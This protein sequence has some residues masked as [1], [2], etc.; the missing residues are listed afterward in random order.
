MPTSFKV[1]Q[2]TGQAVVLLDQRRLP[3]REEYLNCGDYESV[4]TAITEMVVRGAPAIGI[5]AAYG[6]VLGIRD[7]CTTTEKPTSEAVK[8]VSRPLSRHPANR[9]ESLLG[10]RPDEGGRGL[11]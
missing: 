6:V 5:T 4:A 11:C 8:Y 9:R 1:I 2:W 3:T 10:V 7:L